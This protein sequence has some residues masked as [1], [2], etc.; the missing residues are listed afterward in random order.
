M[1][2]YFRSNNARAILDFVFTKLIKLRSANVFPEAVGTVVA[3]D[4]RTNGEYFIFVDHVGAEKNSEM[5][6][7]VE[8]HDPVLAPVVRADLE[9]RMREVLS[10]R[11]GVTVVAIGELERY[12]GTASNTKIRRLLDRR[13]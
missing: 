11:V 3:E 8:V 5:N 13:K 12:T 9:R 2:D 6:V 7:W 10:V 4:R 1:A